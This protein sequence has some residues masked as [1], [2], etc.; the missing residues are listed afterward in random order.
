MNRNRENHFSADPKV[1]LNTL[2][3]ILSPVFALIARRGYGSDIC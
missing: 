1:G 3:W 2:S